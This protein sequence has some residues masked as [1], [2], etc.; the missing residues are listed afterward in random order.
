MNA[1]DK[2][3]YINEKIKLLMYKLAKILA[4]WILE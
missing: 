1:E 4:K 2:L 3:K